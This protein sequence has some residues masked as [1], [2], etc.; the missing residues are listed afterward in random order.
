MQQTV[1][2][3][4]ADADMNVFNNLFIEEKHNEKLRA[5]II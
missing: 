4:M 3:E 5:L 2:L 1:P